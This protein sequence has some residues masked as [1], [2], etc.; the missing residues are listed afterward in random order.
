MDYFFPV[1][2]S[3][4]Q[5]MLKPVGPACNLDCTYCYYL[6][7]KN[8]YPY[9]KGYRLNDDLLEKFIKEYIQAQ[10]V[11]VVSFVW[12][13]GEP[14]MLGVDYF[15]RALKLQE[16]YSEG[17]RIDN[18]LQTNG[19]L[20]T[21]EFCEFLNE[22]NFLVGLSIDGPR[23]LHD[24]YRLTP[25]GGPSWERVM[26]GVRLLKKYK[27]E[28]NTLSVVNN[29]TAEKPVEIYRFLKGIGSQF[30]QFIPIVERYAADPGEDDVHL[31]HHQHKGTAEVTDW[32]VIPSR[33]GNFLVEIFDEWVRKDV[34][35]YYVQLFDVTLANWMGEKNPGLCVFA[36]SCGDAAVM[37]HNGD[38][39]SCDHFVYHD[40][41]LGNIRE[42]SLLDM[43]QQERQARFG[44]EKRTSL[45]KQCLDCEFLFACHGEC[46]KHR[47]QNT[48]QGDPGL[49]YLCEAYKMFFGHVTPYMDYMAKQLKAKKPPANIMQWIKQK[50]QPL[51]ASR[52][53]AGRN[54]PCP[55]GSGKKF[56][57]C[58]INFFK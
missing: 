3:A 15:R 28:F 25:I 49:N 1:K 6:E 19:T 45:P 9:A 34:G 8:L 5:V 27:V 57:Q 38:L 4:F 39:Y 17:K 29:V 40:Y 18:A 52:P 11:P 46:P 30:M 12:Q 44:M 37:E 24:H 41:H 2:R 31:V 14:T 55:C 43:M 47:F 22:K 51:R 35:T 33:Y 10:D 20:L 56:K 32:S 36:E 42:T 54:D 48:G 50:E 58:C 16:K 13:G 23:E 21:D 7:K 26:E 53:A